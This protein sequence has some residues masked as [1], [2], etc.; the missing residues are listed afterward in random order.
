MGH[1]H[2]VKALALTLLSSAVFA[3]AEVHTPMVIWD[4][5]AN[6]DEVVFAWS[7]QLWTVPPSGGVAHRMFNENAEFRKPCFNADGSKLAFCRVDGGEIDVY[8]MNAN[9]GTPQQVTDHPKSDIVQGWTPDGAILFTSGRERDASYELYQRKEGDAL[10][11]RYPIPAVSEASMSPDGNRIAY[12]P[13][14]FFG[15]LVSRRA[16]RGG[17]TAI[18]HVLD[19]KTLKTAAVTK[20]DHNSVFPMWAGDQIYY[21][22][23]SKGSFNLAVYDL[24]AKTSRELT[25]YVT[26]GITTASYSS[27]RI[28]YV[29]DGRIFLYDLSSSTPREVPIT[30]PDDELKT[31]VDERTPRD[32]SIAPYLQWAT[33]TNDGKAALLEA[34]GDI[35]IKPAEGAAVNLTKTAG[36]AERLPSMSPDGSTIA[37][38]SDASGDY[39][40]ALR[41]MSTG[42]VKTIAIEAK[43]TYYRELTWSHD[44]KQVAFSDLRLGLWVADVNAG[45]VRKVDSSP[46]L[47]Q[48][49][50]HPTWAGTRLVYSKAQTNSVRTICA[51]DSTT[52]N[53]QVLTDGYTP[54]ELPTAV[55]ATEIRFVANASGLQ[56][57]ARNIWGLQSSVI[58]SPLVA[59]Q[60]GAISLSGGIRVSP[61]GA[62]QRDIVDLNAGKDGV[63]FAQIQDYGETPGAFDGPSQSL[64][65]VSADGRKWQ[66]MATS[67]NGFEISS[68][69]STL[70]VLG[71]RGLKL[72]PADAPA[73]EGENQ[74]AGVDLS[75]LND[76]ITI[77]QAKEWP[78]LY[79]ETFH[80]MRDR[81]YDPN[82]H[83]QDVDQLERHYAEYLPNIT[84]RS[85]LNILLTMAFGEISISHLRVGGG[86]MGRPL[87]SPK[88][89]GLLGADWDV[90]HGH[91]RITKI[92]RQHDV[93]M[94][95]PLLQP[96]LSDDIKSGMYL[97][98][99]EDQAVT[100]DKGLNSYFLGKAGKKVKLTFSESPDG[101][102]PTETTATAVPGENSLRTLAWVEENSKKVD[103]LSGGKIGYVYIAGYGLDGYQDFIRAL[104]AATN[105][106]GLIIDQRFNGGG[107]TSDMMIDAL[108]KTPI[109]AYEYPY[110]NDFTV[111]EAYVNGPKVLI[112]NQD[113]GSAAETFALMFKAAKVG[114][115]VGTRTFGAG[116]GGGLSGV[117]L[118]DGGS[119]TI[120]NRAGYNPI[121]GEWEIENDGVHPD[122]EVENYPADFA[123]HRDRQLETAVKVAM[124]QATTWKKMQIKRPKPPVHPGGHAG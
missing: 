100:S 17:A 87:G 68:D 92:Y 70:L 44:S 13:Y 62:Q 8:E 10:D 88:S 80:M 4:V 67:I 48:E 35:W 123:A 75:L 108:K 53:I 79:R 28:A 85:D 65:R 121:T 15:T 18:I 56:A 29:R 24:R 9:G 86:D 45:T 89:V 63:I 106:E 60:L 21:L 49:L 23:D 122:I 42:N 118:I 66:K 69:G 104:Y 36:V 26:K 40:L 61:F 82:H 52:G 72:L 115:V 98:R 113:N 110:G 19:T 34:R 77:D 117:Q 120:P 32:V 50:W 2:G 95:S 6:K 27:G 112:I 59:A 22:S 12:V 107:I 90:D 47:A 3:S 38:F 103:E 116:I 16:Y 81:F 30:I 93:L 91:Y 57:P 99:V 94:T 97:I 55:S 7:G 119:V 71:G 43:P 58:L 105:K 51:W 83:G 124:E 101:A 1:D 84:R 111:P 39:Q 33:V 37:Y 14:T 78:Q 109:L 96:I 102:N 54:A 74:N 76:K 114:T 25:S 41:N 73:M 20:G 31:P 46:Y 11:Y 5:A 64:Y